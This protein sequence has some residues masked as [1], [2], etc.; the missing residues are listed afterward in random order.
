MV[1]NVVMMSLQ[2]ICR[3]DVS[4]KIL[5]G[6]KFLNLSQEC[7]FKKMVPT[8]TKILFGRDL[9]WYFLVTIFFQHIVVEMSL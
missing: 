6:T 1:E 4:E 9:F 7:L 3:R 8:C 2:K 5:F